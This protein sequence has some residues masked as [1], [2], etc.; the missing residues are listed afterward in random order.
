MGR[1]KEAG[2]VENGDYAGFLRRALRAHGRRV[3][4]GDLEGLAELVSLKADLDAAIAEAV[5]GLRGEPHAHSWQA[6]ADVL[7]VTR[8]AAMQRWPHAGG[9]RRA[10]GQPTGLR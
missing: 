1:V 6:I 9:A 8:Q 5:E 3:A 7:G 10:G 4:G 2:G